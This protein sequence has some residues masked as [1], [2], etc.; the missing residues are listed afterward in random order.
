MIFSWN[1]VGIST[2][3]SNC[4]T[5]VSNASSCLNSLRIVGRS[6]AG[7]KLII[8]SGATPE[9]IINGNQ[10]ANIVEAYQ[11]L[12]K[13]DALVHDPSTVKSD[14]WHAILVTAV[15]TGGIYYTGQGGGS[16]KTTWVVNQ[17]ISYDD[18]YTWGYVPIT[19]VY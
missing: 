8:S 3:D 18:L 9:T 14:T 5:I 13:G 19:V 1:S 15:G 6:D 7:G 2:P 4:K 11:L 17:W 16:G 10:K 12:Q